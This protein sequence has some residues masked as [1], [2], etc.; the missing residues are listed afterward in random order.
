MKGSMTAAAVHRQYVDGLNA[1][2]AQITDPTLRARFAREA[3]IFFRPCAWGVRTG[4]EGPYLPGMWS[5]TTP[6]LPGN[7]VPLICSRSSPL[8]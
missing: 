1:F 4:M 6:H 3:D 7:P 5:M 8:R 2:R